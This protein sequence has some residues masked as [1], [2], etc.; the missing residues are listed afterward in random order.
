M[1]LQIIWIYEKAEEEIV[2]FVLTITIIDSVT[3]NLSY[4]ISK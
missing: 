2:I 4:R 3:G 1:E